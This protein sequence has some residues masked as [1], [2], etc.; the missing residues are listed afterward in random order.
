MYILFICWVIDLFNNMW[1]LLYKNM[2][3]NLKMW[4]QVDEVKI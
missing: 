3:S 4:G 1:V 2:F